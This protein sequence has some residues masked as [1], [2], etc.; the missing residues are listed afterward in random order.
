MRMNEH[1]IH[2][3]MNVIVSLLKSIIINSKNIWKLIKKRTK[4]IEKIS[5]D[6]EVHGLVPPR[7]ASAPYNV[8]TVKANKKF[9][10]RE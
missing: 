2:S 10:Y 7:S 4:L 6:W 9:I 3:M 1:N 5:D 8:P